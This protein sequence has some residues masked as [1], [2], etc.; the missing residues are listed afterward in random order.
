MKTKKWQMPNEL[1]VQLDGRMYCL[2]TR[3]EKI[4]EIK[5][6]IDRCYMNMEDELEKT[7]YFKKNIKDLQIMLLELNEM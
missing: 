7:R 4:K 6:C 5:H 3:E 1:I 2:L